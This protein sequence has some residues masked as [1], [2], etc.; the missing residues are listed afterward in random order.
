MSDENIQN[1][2]VATLLKLANH[3][4]AGDT[5]ARSLEKKLEFNA[6]NRDVGINIPS[7]AD[8][9]TSKLHPARFLPR[10]ASSL[11]F[12]SKSAK[13]AIPSLNI[14]ATADFDLQPY[15]MVNTISPRAWQEL[16]DASSSN[17]VLKLF[18]PRNTGNTTRSSRIQLGSVEN[19]IDVEE[20]LADLSNM[21]D[22]QS[23]LWTLLIGMAHAR[24][25]DCS[26]LILY[27]Y[28]QN[29]QFH[30]SDFPPMTPQLLTSFVNLVLSHNRTNYSSGKA[31]LTVDEIENR[32]MSFKSQHGLSR[33][34]GFQRNFSAPEQQR[35]NSFQPKGN[36]NKINNF[37]KPSFN[38]GKQNAIQRFSP[39]I[40]R[41]YNQGVCRKDPKKCSIYSPSLGKEIK[42]THI[43]NK[44]VDGREC[45]KNHPAIS[46]I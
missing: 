34:S 33:S 14:K 42:L 20:N 21:K 37:G 13:E 22:V 11:E 30:Q 35:N 19:T 41:N 17:L 5:A 18:S 27:C 36:K 40:C 3:C 29:H 31:P 26:V 15:S 16:F 38:N 10:A 28:M 7:G 46:H 24:P 45:K 32:M 12:I 9:G 25:W 8:N 43:C 44:F 39:S 1:E 6:R 4:S 2:S 23:S